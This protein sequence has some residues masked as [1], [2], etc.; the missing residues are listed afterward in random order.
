MRNP[1]VSMAFAILTLSS[2]GLAPAADSLEGR[3]VGSGAPIANATVTLWAAS[4][5][6]PAQ[7]ARTQTGVDGRFSFTL[8]NSPGSGASLYLIATGGRATSDKASGDNPAIALLT[9]LG[10]EPP[11]RV[12]VNEM[13]TIASVW[14]HAQFLDGAA[15][16]GH[17]L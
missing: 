11:A 15:I 2:I 5:G 10:N 8:S 7:L 13:T 1:V 4:T 3:V 16:K 9:V 14:T 12:V 6:V 17:A